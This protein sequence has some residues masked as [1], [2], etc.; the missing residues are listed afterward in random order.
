MKSGDDDDKEDDGEDDAEGN[1]AS[2]KRTMRR[3]LTIMT[4][5]NMD[6]RVRVRR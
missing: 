5:L 3:K 4:S 1:L 6:M 2:T